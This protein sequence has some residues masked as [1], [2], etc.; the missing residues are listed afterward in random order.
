MRE[1]RRWEPPDSL[2]VMEVR[3]KGAERV[4]YC[5]YCMETVIPSEAELKPT[6]LRDCVLRH[7]GSKCSK[8]IRFAETTPLT[9]GV[10][11]CTFFRFA[12]VLPQ[13]KEQLSLAMPEQPPKIPFFRMGSLSPKESKIAIRKNGAKWS[14]A[15]KKKHEGGHS[16]TSPCKPGRSRR[17]IRAFICC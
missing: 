7:W 17:S 10:I 3:G 15:S 2:R 16:R 6:R 8:C 14:I 9:R 12:A 11:C 13:E 1:R 5:T 4:L